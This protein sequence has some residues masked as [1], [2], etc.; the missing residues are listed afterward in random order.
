[1]AGCS[2]NNELERMW[3]EMVVT[4]GVQSQYLPEEK[5]MNVGRITGLQRSHIP[6]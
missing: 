2:M 5:T 1:M 4:V 6:V 3:K